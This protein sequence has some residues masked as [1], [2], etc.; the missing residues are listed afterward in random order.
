MLLLA[1]TPSFAVSLKWLKNFFPPISTVPTSSLSFKLPFANQWILSHDPICAANNLKM[2]EFAPFSDTLI[3]ETILRVFNASCPNS[4]RK[5]WRALLTGEML[6][7]GTLPWM[8]QTRL[9]DALVPLFFLV[10]I[11]TLLHYF[12]CF[13]CTS[14][15][16]DPIENDVHISWDGMTD[17]KEAIRGGVLLY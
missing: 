15:Q 3:I 9:Y 11:W 12:D 4:N 17:G 5:M 10:A 1:K 13:F 14:F 6:S 7:C 8:C 2:N 16:V